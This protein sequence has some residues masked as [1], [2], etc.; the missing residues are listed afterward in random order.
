MDDNALIEASRCWQNCLLP[1]GIILVSD[2]ITKQRSTLRELLTLLKF[3][4]TNGLMTR[5]IVSLPQALIGY[6]LKSK[7]APLVYRDIADLKKLFSHQN[8][9]STEVK[10]PNMFPTRKALVLRRF[11]G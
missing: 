1:G 9:A 3:V 2:I 7:S 4:F 10:N 5:I 6:Y 8:F 11:G